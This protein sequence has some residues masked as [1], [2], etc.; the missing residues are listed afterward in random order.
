MATP[1]DQEPR[2]PQLHQAERPAPRRRRADNTFG[3]DNKHAGARIPLS[4]S[5]LV[6]K[7]GALH[8]Y[9]AHADSFICS[10]VP[11]TPTDQTTYTRGGLLFKLSDSNMEYITSRL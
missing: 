11:G 10:M 6:Q 8:E 3:W 5:F 9:K 1:G 4:K 7:V 2:L